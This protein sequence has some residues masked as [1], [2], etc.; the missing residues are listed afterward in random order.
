[1]GILSWFTRAPPTVSRSSPSTVDANGYDAYGTHVPSMGHRS[2]MQFVDN[3]DALKRSPGFA[4]RAVAGGG[5]KKSPAAKKP[6]AKK[7]VSKKPAAKKAV[8][9]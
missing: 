7:S 5:K 9:K 4:K 6:A 8:K 3:H 1:M 2:V